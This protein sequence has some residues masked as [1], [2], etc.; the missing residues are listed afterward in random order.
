MIANRGSLLRPAHEIAAGFRLQV[1]EGNWAKQRSKPKPNAQPIHE[2]KL[3]EY[4][5]ELECLQVQYP[6]SMQFP[7]SYTPSPHMASDSLSITLSDEDAGWMSRPH[8]SKLR[9]LS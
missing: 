2:C 5:G 1:T 8:V 4:V 6:T 9:V 3:L 7:N